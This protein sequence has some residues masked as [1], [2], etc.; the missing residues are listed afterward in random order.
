MLVWEDLVGI[1]VPV[2][3]LLALA[4]FK[5]VG[6]TPAAAPVLLQALAPRV[7]EPPAC[8][9]LIRTLVPGVS[10]VLVVVL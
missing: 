5:T 7:L 3:A 2:V 6:V 4:P 1:K 8:S 9:W 10:V